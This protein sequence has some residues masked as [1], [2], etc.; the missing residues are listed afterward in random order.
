M[1]SAT[2]EPLGRAFKKVRDT[3]QGDA[4]VRLA[5]AVERIKAL[6]K[7][8]SEI[9]SEVNR[10]AARFSD[11]V[12]QCRATFERDK[13]FENELALTI[14]EV[15]LDWHRS[16]STTPVE[17]AMMVLS[18]GGT[19]EQ[20]LEG[21]AFAKFSSEIT[22]WRLPLETALKA[23]ISIARQAHEETLATVRE[24]LSEFDHETVTNDPRVK[25]S[26]RELARQERLLDRFESA[27]NL[28]AWRLAIEDL[29][30]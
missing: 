23:N 10:H 14:A 12:S 26:G 5:A 21:Q 11:Y 8:L 13:T 27:E 17:R 20:T 22:D 6:R 29:F 4:H 16:H 3:M 18:H 1:S 24:Q 25:R 7:R 28:S 19:I 15:A 9:E 2:L 30:P